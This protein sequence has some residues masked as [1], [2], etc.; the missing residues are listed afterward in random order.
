MSCSLYLQ[1]SCS[2]MEIRH[3]YKKISSIKKQYV[4]N[5]NCECVLKGF[6][7]GREF[8]AVELE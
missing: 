5:A 3:M 2:L 8:I 4:I 6:K 1:E 7:R